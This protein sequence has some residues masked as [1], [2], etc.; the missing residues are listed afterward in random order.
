[1]DDVRR[2]AVAGG[3]EWDIACSNDALR[4]ALLEAGKL[5]PGLVEWGL[6]RHC[7]IS[8]VCGRTVAVAIGRCREAG[9]A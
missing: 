5:K 1:M 7:R 8:L 9:C 2:N 3:I 4:L 6:S